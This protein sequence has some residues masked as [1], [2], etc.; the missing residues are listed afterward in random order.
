LQSQFEVFERAMSGLR[1]V[2]A[3]TARIAKAAI[4]VLAL[5]AA[6]GCT[7]HAEPPPEVAAAPP[8]PPPPQPP[9]I[10]VAGRWRLAAAGGGACFM[11]F[12]QA[13]G[14]GQGTIAPEGGCPGNFFTSRKWTFEH[15]AMIIRDHKSEVL[16]ELSLAGGRFEGH[17][18]GGGAIS[19][20]R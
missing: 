2:S 10:Q 3:L 4:V 8:P 1:N 18:T 6:G 15:G 11:N 5:A 9:P 14:A 13:A 20:S 7:N 16:A 17:Q 12:A 19:L